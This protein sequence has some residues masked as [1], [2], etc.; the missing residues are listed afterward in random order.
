MAAGAGRCNSP[1]PV[2]LRRCT[3]WY[4]IEPMKRLVTAF[5]ALAFLTTVVSVSFAQKGDDTTMNKKKKG[6]TSKK[7]KRGE[8]TKKS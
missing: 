4:I 2:D 5:L 8:D 6:K 1:M 7:T 3:N